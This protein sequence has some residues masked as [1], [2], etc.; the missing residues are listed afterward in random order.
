MFQHA[1]YDFTLASGGRI[2]FVGIGGISM[3]GLAEIARHDGY[4]VAGSDRNLTPR[5]DHLVRQGI[6][7][8]AG[9]DAAWI[10]QFRPD[11]VVYTA[12]VHDDNPELTRAREQGI[13]TISR[14]A[15]LGWLNRH[16]QQIINISGTHG[17]TTTTALCALILIE[18]GIDPT[19]HLGAEL[20]EFHGTIRLGQPSGVMVSEAC[21][22]MRSFLQFYSTTAAILNI[23]YDHVD[24][25]SNLDAV[26][27]AFAEFADHLPDNG[28][29]VVP[30][31]DLNI[32]EMLRQLHIRRQQAGRMMPRICR[33][34]AESDLTDGQKPDFYYSDL[35]Y[36]QGMPEFSIWHDSRLYCRQKLQIPGC[37]N[38]LNSLAAVACASFSGGTAEAAAKALAAYQGAEGRFTLTGEYRGAQVIADYAHHPSAVRATLAAAAHLPHRHT[39][40]VF[41]PLTYSRTRILL[42]DFAAALKGCE[43]VIL[44]EIY[45]DRETN[46]HDISSRDLAERI[47]NLGGHAVFAE[48]FSKIRSYLDLVV[49]QGD[50]ILVLGPED[51]RNF[52]DQLT[53]R[54]NPLI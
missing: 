12:A 39:W 13:R 16:F 28:V 31:F 24:C 20:A 27:G 22:Y 9:H 52:A 34:G 29:L 15:F 41:Q 5:T 33:F 50:L 42:D 49:Q 17:K 11:L 35:A 36:H 6:A 54:I 37:H 48:S 23:D 7:V 10:D 26:I 30:A 3:S 38:M 51:I 14:A 8:R 53:G 2:F 47:N 21:E 25:Y 19:V 44:A 46:L 45:S 43:K 40:V 18:S 4:A 32:R 1:D